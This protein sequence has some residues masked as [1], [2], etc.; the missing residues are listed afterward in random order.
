M[1]TDWKT[2]L[3]VRLFPAQLRKG[4]GDFT[5]PV[6]RVWRLT[7]DSAAISVTA[8]IIEIVPI[9]VRRDV[10]I[11]PR[12]VVRVVVR[13]GVGVEIAAVCVAAGRAAV[14]DDLIL[15]PLDSVAGRRVSSEVGD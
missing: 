14:L 7:P 3:P 4:P 9:V 11:V 8:L 12:I 2:R 15:Y 1:G 10:G 13:I 6:L 5:R